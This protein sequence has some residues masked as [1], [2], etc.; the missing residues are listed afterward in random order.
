MNKLA[1]A[2]VAV[3]V[4]LAGEA[5]AQTCTAD[6][7]CDGESICVDGTCVDPNQAKPDDAPKETTQDDGVT[8][9][10]SGEDAEEA[11]RLP[12]RYVSRPLTLPHLILRPAASLSVLRISLFGESET[13]VQL[14]LG[15]SFGL[16]DDLELGIVILPL[17]LSPDF[18]YG[19]VPVLVRYRFLAEMV[20]IGAELL[21]YIPT[22]TDFGLTPAL[23]VRIHGG[24]II[25]VDTGLAIPVRFGSDERGGTTVALGIPLRLNFQVIDMIFAGVETGFAMIL[26]G[27]VLDVVSRDETISIPLGFAAGFTLPADAGPLFDIVASFSFPNFLV[28]AADD[29]LFTELYVFSLTFMFHIFL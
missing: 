1:W 7:D 28:P 2:V 20:E 4:V 13:A 6:V 9:R 15:A 5:G 25:S 12:V 14:G 27:D 8:V 26:A 17:L 16:F 10:F 18:D 11:E 22:N 3:A 21:A 23:A 19:D 29:K 24:D